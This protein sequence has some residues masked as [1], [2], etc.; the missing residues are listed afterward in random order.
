ME[1]YFMLTQRTLKAIVAAIAITGAFN[2]QAMEKKNAKQPA[3]IRLAAWAASQVWYT[4]KNAV[5]FAL[6]PLRNPVIAGCVG[7]ASYPI[8]KET[9]FAATPATHADDVTT[10]AFNKWQ[11]NIANAKRN[12]QNF[13]NN[14]NA[15]AN[16]TYQQTTESVNNFYTNTTAK[17]NNFVNSVKALAQNPRVKFAQE[18]FAQFKSTAA[19][20]AQEIADMI[21]KDK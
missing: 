8:L 9:L 1:V 11:R 13:Y 6:K 3:A 18:K 15:I 17:V 16:A 20:K 10:R 2:M 4:G 19:Q 5:K 21:R 14:S 7:L 12:S